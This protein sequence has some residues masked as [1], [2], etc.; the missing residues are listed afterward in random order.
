MSANYNSKLIV[1]MSEER[2]KCLSKLNEIR[3][4]RNNLINK[5]DTEKATIPYR[6]YL[7]M[8]IEAKALRTELSILAAE[9][10]TWDKARE[11]CMRAEENR[12]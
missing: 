1:A 10:D 4:R 3:K 5:L 2:K 6:D 12:L 7:E 9:A 8:E 11:L